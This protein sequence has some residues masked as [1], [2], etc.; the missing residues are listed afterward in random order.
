MTAFEWEMYGDLCASHDQQGLD[1]S[2]VL[3]AHLIEHAAVVRTSEYIQLD[4]Y[5]AMVH[6]N[7]RKAS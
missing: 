6:H 2:P 5:D 3:Q 7:E 1:A 4:R